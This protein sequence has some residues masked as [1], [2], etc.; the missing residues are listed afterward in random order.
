MDATRPLP[1]RSPGFRTAKP[2]W[3][4]APE[5]ARNLT[6]AATAPFL[7]P[8]RD[9][10][11]LRITGSNVYRVFVDGAFVHDGPARAGHG[12]YRVDEIP[13]DLPPGPHLLAIECLSCGVPSYAHLKAEGFLQ[14]EIVSESGTLVATGD[15]A[16]RMKTLP[17]R[18]RRVERYSMQRTFAEAYRLAPG[19]DA[20]RQHGI[21]DAQTE[22][23]RELAPRRLLPRRIH[24]PE[25]QLRLPEQLV[26]I[27]RFQ[28]ESDGERRKLWW[29]QGVLENALDSFPIETLEFDHVRLL[30]GLRFDPLE[31]S[32]RTLP[33]RLTKGQLALFDLGVNRTGSIRLEVRAE[34]AATVAVR[35]DERAEGPAY[36]MRIQG[37]LD[38]IPWFL[39]AGTYAVET[40]E[41]YTFRYLKVLVLEGEIELASVAVREAAYDA[42][43]AARF[44]CSDPVLNR[45]FEAGRE[46]FRQNAFDVYM[47]CPGRERAG[48]LCDSY[49]TAQAEPWLCGDSRVETNFLENF[50]LP[51][52]FPHL[53]E[54]MLPMCYPSDHV[55]ERFIP[56]WA[57]W[58]VIQLRAFR[59]RRGSP[60]LLDALRPRVEGLLGFLEPFENQD[61]LL[62]SLPSW[63]F[64]E[65]SEA[66]R[67]T[68]DVNYPT[69]MLYAGTLEAASELLGRHDLRGRAG[70]IRERVRAQSFDGA[71]F[72]DRALR[73]EDGS[74]EVGPET[75]EAAQYY[76]FFFEV[77][78]PES[79]PSLWQRLLHELGPDR[80]PETVHP[81]LSPANVFI[82]FYLR[83]ELLR[84]KGEGPRLLREVRGLYAEMARATGTLWENKSPKGSL[85]HGFTSCLCATIFEQAGG[86]RINWSERTASLQ[87]PAETGLTWSEMSVPTPE[88]WI[89]ARWQEDGP[90]TEH[91][92]L[93][94]EGWREADRIASPDGQSSTESPS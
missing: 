12:A 38:V 5:E 45:V 16:F 88:G 25:F 67:L 69:N 58:F 42:A 63:N 33:Q 18:I 56:Q 66:N 76:A 43:A 14:A 11:L 86:L 44:S 27:G 31:D 26:G 10:A 23:T 60:E 41:P 87:P 52:R 57:M 50:A 81:T 54:G 74:L 7:L 30:D 21:R 92:L 75:T 24:R 22:T 51:D 70:R 32:P 39:A 89:H 17:G 84:R 47:D 64:I 4:S 2:I 46:T 8:E 85:N 68:K 80:N 6:V 65:W 36:E 29:R 79:H 53:P 93:L 40:A 71:W 90:A 13:L 94:P 15:T 91:R 37:T 28:Q 19:W 59:D 34:T 77:A 72:H 62:E 48:W 73:R 35:F 49:F 83:M 3:L 9:R 55:N 1:D 20:W 78:T 61:G 82:G